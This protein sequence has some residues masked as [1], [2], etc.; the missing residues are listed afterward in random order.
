MTKKKAIIKDANGDVVSEIVSQQHKYRYVM[1]PVKPEIKVDLIEL[2]KLSGGSH[3][4][5]GAMVGKLVR[6][7]LAKART[8]IQERKP[9]R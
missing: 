6:D 9:S 3:R 7:A 1:V 5:Q 4:S 8:E 2:C